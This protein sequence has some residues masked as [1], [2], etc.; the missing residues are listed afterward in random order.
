MRLSLD[1]SGQRFVIRGFTQT[2]VR[3]N[4]DEYFKSFLLTPERIVSD[5]SFKTVSELAPSSLNALMIDDPEVLIVGTGPRTQR[6]SA[7]VQAAFL[8]AGAGIEFMDT[9]AACRTFT[10]LASELRRVSLLVLFQENEP[11]NG[12]ENTSDNAHA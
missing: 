3:V 11:E 6:A 8:R 10:V 12:P 1:D 4:H 9:G 5:L 2:S 7:A